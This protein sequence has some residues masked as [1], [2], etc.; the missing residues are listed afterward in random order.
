[1]LLSDAA[2]RLNLGSCE[3][4]DPPK[5]QLSADVP[6]GIGVSPVRSG[7]KKLGSELFLL[8]VHSGRSHRPR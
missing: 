2:L 8:K 4:D 3:D 1:M 6:V 5:F 7:L